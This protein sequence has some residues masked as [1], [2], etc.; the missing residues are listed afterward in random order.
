M[1]IKTNKQK[2]FAEKKPKKPKFNFKH[3]PSRKN[4]KY[5]LNYENHSI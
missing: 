4:K 1:T 3:D 2:E 5:Y